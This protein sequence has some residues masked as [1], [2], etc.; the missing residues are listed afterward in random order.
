MTNSL[1]NTPANKRGGLRHVLRH[2]TPL[3]ISALL[4]IIG[5]LFLSSFAIAK[6]PG[7]KGLKAGPIEVIATPIGSF[8]KINPFQSQFG[9]LT[10]LGGLTLSSPAKNF[11]GWSDIA[12]DRDGGRILAVSDGGIWLS[13]GLKYEG[14]QVKALADPR[15]GPLR[16][17]SGRA[18]R[19]KR[20]RDAEGLTLIDGNIARGNFLVSFERIHRIG[21]F[22]S[23]KSGVVGP[24]RYLKLPKKAR[25]LSR[26]KGLEAVA[27]LRGGRLKG[28]VVT[29]GER[30]RK[31][32][33]NRKGWILRK[34]KSK[35]FELQDIGDF[36]VTSAAGLDDGSLLVLERR[37][38]MAEWFKGIRIRLR[39]IS[40]A[41]LQKGGVLRGETLLE[42]NSSNEIDNMEGL[43]VH[44][45]PDGTTIITMISDDNFN[46]FLQRTV[47]LQFALPANATIRADG[48][49]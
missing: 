28:A 27:I 30:P 34:G 6:K 39:R 42:A 4:A 45:R 1:S 48:R 19:G 18:L 47:L 49:N 9:E 7:S 20:E 22:R 16:A 10:F 31:G 36:D 14:G 46:K 21:H 2:A 35:K 8:S 17:L 23:G 43:S 11:G 33:G 3:R 37:F 13:A 12:I 38:R 26:N 40:A 44:R 41:D 32:R 5:T 25:K 29:F 24:V 15:I